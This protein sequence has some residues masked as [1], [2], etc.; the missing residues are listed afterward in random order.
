MDLVSAHLA[1]P[2]TRIAWGFHLRAESVIHFLEYIFFVKVRLPFKPFFYE[3]KNYENPTK[4]N[5]VCC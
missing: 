3:E 5:Y 4:K 1:I 2:A